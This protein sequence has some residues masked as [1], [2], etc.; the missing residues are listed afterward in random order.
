MRLLM[1]S[2]N[3]KYDRNKKIKKKDNCI[4]NKKNTLNKESAQ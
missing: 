1:K 4:N 2:H 3:I